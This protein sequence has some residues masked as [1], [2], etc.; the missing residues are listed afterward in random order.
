MNICDLSYR[1]CNFFD[2]SQI[3]LFFN[4]NIDGHMTCIIYYWIH[5][6]KPI[7]HK[8]IHDLRP[9]SILYLS[10][11]RMTTILYKC[12]YAGVQPDN[13]FLTQYFCL[14]VYQYYPFRIFIFAEN[15]NNCVIR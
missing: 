1:I 15:N 11:N 8:S 14:K 9:Y 7:S 13:L 4:M 5:I 12:I 2:L 10:R 3:L 6:S